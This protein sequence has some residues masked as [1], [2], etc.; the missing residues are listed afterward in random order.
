MKTITLGCCLAVFA[1]GIALANESQHAAIVD[2]PK[3]VTLTHASPDTWQTLPPVQP[4][5]WRASAFD[6][7]LGQALNGFAQRHP[8]GLGTEL[9]FWHRL[10]VCTAMSLSAIDPRR[11]SVS[12]SHASQEG[13]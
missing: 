7:R 1:Y 9:T 3:V 6:A 8:Q 5:E 12:R 2:M 10:S 4:N 11:D 13:K